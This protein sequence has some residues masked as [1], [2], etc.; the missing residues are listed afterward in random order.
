VKADRALAL[1]AKLRADLAA[2]ELSALK[3]QVHT[4]LAKLRAQQATDELLAVDLAEAL[5]KHL[6]TL[7]DHAPSMQPA[8]RAAVVGAAR[9]FVSQDDAIPD[10]EALTGMDDDVLVFN[11]V[12][13]EIGRPDLVIDE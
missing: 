7:L 11:S 5:A 1:L 3:A 13:R 8:Y 4:H 2:E 12:A 10:G 9:Y 6:V